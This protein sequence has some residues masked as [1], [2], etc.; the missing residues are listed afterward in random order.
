MSLSG[1]KIFAAGRFFGVANG[2]DP[3]PTVFA[4]PQDQ[5][6]GFKRSVKSL[7]GENQ[8]PADISSG[9]MEVTGKVSLGTLNPR[10]FADL[11]FAVTGANS[12]ILEANGELGTVSTTHIVVANGATFS[13]DLGVFNTVSGAR[14]VRVAAS[15]EVAGV[16]YSVNTA[17]GSYRFNAA[18]SGV[19]MKISYLYTAASQ[20]ELL[21]LTNAQMG[22][23]GS[24]TAVMQF[25]WAS[26]QSV[27]T[28][29]K[30]LGTDTE[31]ATKL[32]DYGKPTFGFMAGCDTN[33]TLGTFSFSE[34]A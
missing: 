5:S 6:I 23:I 10:M 13:T 14:Y 34:A 24:F 3:T 12:Q 29:N 27:L 20:G 8:L 4:I 31:I 15:S 1:Q 21:T 11:L 17:T 32:D 19:V 33:A 28:L 30:C 9:T 2:T 16:S 25:N 26:E 18:D 22:N 7:F